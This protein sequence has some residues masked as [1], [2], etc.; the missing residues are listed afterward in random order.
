MRQLGATTVDKYAALKDK[1]RTTAFQERIP[2]EG[3]IE[4]TGRCNF[5]C[6]HCFRPTDACE[7]LP[8]ETVARMVDEMV[9]CGCLYLTITGG[10]PLLHRDFLEMHR[11]MRKS[12]LLTILFTNGSL[13]NEK[14]VE[15]LLEAP[16]IQVEVSVYGSSSETYRAITGHP[17]GYD[18]T[19]RAIEMLLEAGLSVHLK[20]V[21]IR[22]N[23]QEFEDLRKMA[24]GLGVTWDYDR[25]I[26]PKVDGN[27]KPL[28]YR[29]TPGEI[30]GAELSD[31]DSSSKWVNAFRRDSNSIEQ[32]NHKVV[33][34]AGTSVFVIDSL[35]RLHPC[36]LWRTHPISLEDISFKEAWNG[37]LADISDLRLELPSECVSCR[38]AGFCTVCPAWSFI[39]EGNRGIRLG[40]MCDLMRRR[41]ET[42]S[43][44][45]TNV[46]LKKKWSGGKDISSYRNWDGMGGCHDREFEA[47]GNV[48]RGDSG[49][50]T[51]GETDGRRITPQGGNGS[52]SPVP[53]WP[54]TTDRGVMLQEGSS[55]QDG[56]VLSRPVT[57]SKSDIF[58]RG[59]NLKLRQIAGHS[60]L[61]PTGKSQ[62]D[63]IIILNVGRVVA[64]VWN[65]LGDKG[66]SVLEI[67]RYL[68]FSNDKQESVMNAVGSLYAKDAIERLTN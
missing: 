31:L 10:E 26:N 59:K 51:S 47:G 63:S 41:Q 32:G 12:G 16:P 39:E 15:G 40:F 57:V 42:F 13:V 67:E 66:L 62:G 17:E 52:V 9:D 2:L 1:L 53:G 21:I 65:A 5:N 22:Q 11:Y 35:A 43:G 18:R 14:V 46:D 6:I 56:R 58:T 45:A 61:V 4:L 7:D 36:V 49:K 37:P 64:D 24:E 25:C 3:G 27:R 8:A 23:H 44:S 20:T 54:I 68:G 29:L 38:L 50:P 30:V 55:L 60:L 34:N 19:L 48:C 33:C 28:E